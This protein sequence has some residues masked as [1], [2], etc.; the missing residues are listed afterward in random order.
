MKFCFERQSSGKKWKSNKKNTKFV[1][2]N[3]IYIYIYIY[4]FFG[5]VKV[6]SIEF[7]VIDFGVWALVSVSKD[8]GTQQ[9]VSPTAL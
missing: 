3:V 9:G 6:S 5:C 8:G 2:I 4:V 1:Y 7:E